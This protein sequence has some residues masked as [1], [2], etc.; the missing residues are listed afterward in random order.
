MCLVMV[1]VQAQR[2]APALA[3]SQR[4]AQLAPLLP[5]LPEGPQSLLAAYK[6][7]AMTFQLH[8]V[9]QAPVQS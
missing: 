5:L 8:R 3:E 6:Q 1:P 2:P 4:Q 9:S 7:A